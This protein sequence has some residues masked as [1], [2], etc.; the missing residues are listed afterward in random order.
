VAPDDADP[1]EKPFRPVSDSEISDLR[2]RATLRKE[3]SGY[4]DEA[5][6]ADE[7]DSVAYYNLGRGDVAGAV[8]ARLSGLLPT[9][10]LGTIAELYERVA[11]ASAQRPTLRGSVNRWTV[12][13]FLGVLLL[14]GGSVLSVLLARSNAE[15][16]GLFALL[17]IVGGYAA[18]RS[19]PIG[20]QFS[21]ARHESLTA[22]R[23]YRAAVIRQLVNPVIRE[24]IN[25]RLYDYGSKLTVRSSPGL[26]TDDPLFRIDT[27]N[28][29]QLLNLMA[30]MPDGG[31]IGIA[32]PRGCGKTTLLRALCTAELRLP[33]GRPPEAVLVTAPIEF[34]PR[35][36]LLHLFGR[37]CRQC[38]RYT[39]LGEFPL[40]A[41]SPG[42][43]RIR[44]QVGLIRRHP[45]KTT[46]LGILCLAASPLVAYA[47]LPPARQLA[48]WNWL[49]QRMAV[50]FGKNHDQVFAKTNQIWH[51]LHS[52][53]T[54]LTVISAI[55]FLVGLILLLVAAAR[56]ASSL[57]V[58]VVRQDKETAIEELARRHLGNIRF[59]QSYSYGWSGSLTVPIAQVGINEALSLAEYQQSLP[60]IV[61]TMREF[62]EQIASKSTP[63]IIAVDELDK[64]ASDVTAAQFLNDLKGIFGVRHCFYLVSVSEDAMSN[65]EL[66]G[67]PFRDA[68]DST[69]DEVLH[70][71]PLMYRESRRLLQRRV[72]G[73]SAAYL[74]LC[75]C[76]AGG[77]PRDLVRV[78]RDLVETGRRH[79]RMCDVVAAL[80][81]LDIRGRTH[82][83]MIA[84][85]TISAR[86]EIEPMALWIDQIS[87]CL[88]GWPTARRDASVPMSELRAQELLELCGR[89]PA[90][91][92]DVTLA[93]AEGKGMEGAASAAR[94]LGLG[95]A[96]SLYYLATVIELFRDDRTKTEFQELDGSKTSTTKT[97]QV[98]YLAR[99]R[100]A[101]AISPVIA[102]KQISEFR[103]SWNMS[104]LDS[105]GR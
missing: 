9:I 98:E 93:A 22:R 20:R 92:Y 29:R 13:V 41:G 4:V 80:V 1:D 90:D 45:A 17:A 10:Q 49:R 6:D 21:N 28:S 33:S 8:A 95:L 40:P 78:A 75:Q 88:A 31:S 70:L 57:L 7:F 35:D 76:L 5:I 51:F 71:R 67:F 23:R 48:V 47:A 26:M 104:V 18:R 83:T 79:T 16:A 36:F 24:V 61:A 42:T 11:D 86:L 64:V 55:L 54:R 102:W 66:R 14:L 63:V 59:Q 74:C 39:S 19:W 97:R 84:L 85:R 2:H 52:L 62:L 73:L 34:A 15:T 89:Y 105:P 82:A 103:A 96:G 44:R 77:L 101:F 87:A 25:D 58:F 43:T 12:A 68:F 38:L 53:D 50:F 91:V 56:L 32:G 3:I 60:D 27:D 100:Q 37:I 69:F 99:A 94:R 72:V 46:L 65:F 81:Q 30:V